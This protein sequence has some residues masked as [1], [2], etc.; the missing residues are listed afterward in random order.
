MEEEQYFRRQNG[1][2][3]WGDRRPG[4]ISTDSRNH[5]N[6][7]KPGLEE[8]GECDLGQ[9]QIHLIDNIP[10]RQRPYRVPY[11]LKP[12]MR[13]QINILLEAGIIQP[14]NNPYAAPVLLVRKPDG[15]YRLVSDLRKLNE[16]TIPDNFPLPN[17]TEMVDM[18]SGAKFFTSMNLTSG[19]H[20]MKMHPDHAFLTGIAT[21]FDVFEFKRLPFG[22]RNASASFKRLMSLVLAGLSHLQIGC[23]IDDIII[24]SK[25]VEDHL[26][27]LE[28]VFK[29]LIDA[30]LRVKLVNVLSFRKKLHTWDTLRFIPNYSKTALPLTNLTKENVPFNWSIIEQTAFETFKN[31][32]TLEPCLKLPDFS[33]PFSLCSD[34]NKF[35]LGAVLVQ[36]DEG[37]FQHP[38]TFASRKLSKSEISY[39]V[40]EKET[41][42]VVFGVT[43]FKSYLYGR[44]FTAYL[45]QQCLFS[46]LSG[47]V[48]FLKRFEK[49]ASAEPLSILK[50]SSSQ[51]KIFP[52]AQQIKSLPPLNC[53]Q[54]AT[55]LE[56]RAN[57]K[58]P[59][60]SAWNLFK[61]GFTA[62]GN[63]TCRVT[64]LHLL[65][66]RCL[67]LPVSITPDDKN[68]HR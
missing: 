31:A 21:K 42:G 38:V 32:L 35:A 3:N 25:S 55:L 67:I 12:E 27:K 7:H 36:D 54:S 58:N 63:P 53:G 64:K 43:Q 14:S 29:R 2:L 37:G 57:R 18:L 5:L 60:Y 50:V 28:I 52:K 33:K 34:A 10:T 48:F 41:L 49:R 9:H 8:L 15:N 61:L 51:Q 6:E 62:F 13:R 30:N 45:D 59:F 20:Q 23:H 1:R 65:S 19:F 24:A 11:A 39:S 46:P 68:K 17:L 4:N 56:G 66:S 47:S 16:K 26:S 22:L 40:V 44:K